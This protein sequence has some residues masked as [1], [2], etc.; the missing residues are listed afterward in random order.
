MRIFQCLQ[1]AIRML[2]ADSLAI[3]RQFVL[4]QQLPDSSFMNKNGQSD[5]YYTAFGWM[6]IYILDIQTDPEKM[7]AYLKKQV[8]NEWDLIHNAARIRCWLLTELIKRGRFHFL[9]TYLFN[10]K[11]GDKAAGLKF[12]DSEFN[13][14]YELYIRLSMLEDSSRKQINRKKMLSDPA[15]FQLPEGGY[16]NR[17]Y[18]ASCA[19]NATSA[20]LMVYGQLEGYNNP[21]Q[22][23]FLC[24]QQ[25]ASGGFCAAQ[26]APVPDLLSTA[27]VLFTLY[28]YGIKPAVDPL[29][30]IDAHWHES[31]GFTATLLD[32]H[33]DVEYTF[34]GLLALGTTV[35]KRK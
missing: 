25:H 24:K 18:N 30:F 34:Y 15:L 26:N 35:W 22:T 2:S 13:T 29:D 7:R 32:D 11:Y 19:T 27:T 31:G 1:Q 6:L 4:S 8:V 20:A 28:N 9:I 23:D 21:E 3:V 12:N 17:L 14:P 5:L 16:S 10:Q 33:C